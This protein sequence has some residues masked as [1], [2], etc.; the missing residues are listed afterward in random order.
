M[1]ALI[2]R[3]DLERG[4]GTGRRLLEDQGDVLPD[5][6]RLLVAQYFAAFRFR[7]SWRRKRSSAEVKSSS[8]T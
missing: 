4:P 5:E 8:F 2:V 3:S 7:D 6:T 1:R